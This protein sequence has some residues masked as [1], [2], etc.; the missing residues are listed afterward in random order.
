MLPELHFVGECFVAHGAEPR[1]VDAQVHGLRVV[2]LH[3]VSVKISGE[4]G[5]GT[6]RAKIE[7]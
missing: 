2:T 7:T 5:V 3:G 6:S 4:L 1:R